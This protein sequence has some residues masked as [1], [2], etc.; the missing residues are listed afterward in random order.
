MSDDYRPV[1]GAPLNPAHR[2]E[3]DG[4]DLHS[5]RARLWKLEDAM[6]VADQADLDV[7]REIRDLTGMLESLANRV[8]VLEAQCGKPPAFTT[9]LD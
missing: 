6:R 4:R 8:L 2:V 5:I 7:R 9:L 1:A 3:I